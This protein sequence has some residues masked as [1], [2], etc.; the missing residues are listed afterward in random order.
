[1]SVD[2]GLN[3]LVLGVKRDRLQERLDQVQGAVAA[4]GTEIFAFLGNQSLKLQGHLVSYLEK[5]SPCNGGTTRL[6]LHLP[7]GACSQRELG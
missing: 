2:L 7:G 6:V 3:P 4:G 5:R 1:M